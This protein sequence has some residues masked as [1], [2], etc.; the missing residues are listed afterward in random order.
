MAWPLGL[1]FVSFRR[2]IAFSEV[3]LDGRSLFGAVGNDISLTCIPEPSATA[4]PTG[5]SPLGSQPH[6]W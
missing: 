4:P 1:P 5:A 3:G 6:H 2:E